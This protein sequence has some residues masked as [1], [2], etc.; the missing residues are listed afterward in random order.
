MNASKENAAK[1]RKVLVDLTTMLTING[2]HGSVDLDFLDE[3]LDA[4]HAKLPTEEAF[5]KE[6]KRRSRAKANTAHI[7][8]SA[9]SA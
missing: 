4:A 3:F 5:A 9:G 7:T 8:S 2:I 1:A 6:K